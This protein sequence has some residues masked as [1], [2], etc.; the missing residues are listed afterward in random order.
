MTEKRKR[1]L[2]VSSAFYP[3]ISPRSYRATELAKEFIRQNLEVVVI[4]KHRSYDYSDFCRSFPLELFMWNKDSFPQIPV[5]KPQPLAKLSNYMSRFLKLFFEYPNIEEMFRVRGMLKT[6]SGYEL[7]IS[8]AVPYPVHWGVALARNEHHRIADVWV[9]DCGDPYMGDVLDTFRKPFYFKYLE[10]LF[11]RKADFLT[12]PIES[13]RVGYYPEFH[14]KIR[15]IPQGFDFSSKND[16]TAKPDNTVPVFAYAGGFI[17]G[18]RDPEPLLEFLSKLNLRFKFYVFTNKPHLLDHY[19]NPLKGK[20]FV[21][22]YIPRDKLMQILSQMDFLVNF[23]NNTKL[24]SPSKLIDYSITGRPVLNIT[25]YFNHNDVLAFLQGDYS[26][27]MILPAP[28]YFHIKSVA[29]LFM[30]LIT[31]K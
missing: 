28:E 3:E 8:F 19:I 20:L 4:T 15:I 11:C 2:L 7:M 27:K 24:N 23:D 13:A 25:K 14:N 16:I 18:I 12:I 26:N 6:Q 17:P 29:K 5:I 10:R 22:E 1:I 9:A 30:D 21:S 31:E